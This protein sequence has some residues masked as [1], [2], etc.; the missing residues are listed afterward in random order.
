M[1]KVSTVHPTVWA[2]HLNKAVSSQKSGRIRYY[3]RAEQQSPRFSVS[4]I[5]DLSIEEMK[6]A[7]DLHY[8]GK[9]SGKTYVD[10][11]TSISRDTRALIQARVDKRNQLGKRMMRGV[12]YVIAKF[13]AI[14]FAKS[15]LSTLQAADKKFKLEIDELQARLRKSEESRKL[16]TVKRERSIR[17]IYLSLKQLNKQYQTDKQIKKILID[18]LID[19]CKAHKE[20]GASVVVQFEKDVGRDTTFK[21]HDRLMKI[22]D[23]HSLPHLPKKESKL[24]GYDKKKVREGVRLIQELFVDTEDQKWE[25][26][27]QAIV[28]QTGFNLLYIP[29]SNLLLEK[30]LGMAQDPQYSWQ[31]EEAKCGMWVTNRQTPVRLDI[32]RDEKKHIKQVNV[33]LQLKTD[34]VS[35]EYGVPMTTEPVMKDLCML[36]MNFSIT[37]KKDGTPNVKNIKMHA[38]PSSRFVNLVK[39]GLSHL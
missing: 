8:S 35:Q 18:G 14:F 2:N 38:R 6:Q 19:D 34:A 5:V 16:E 39:H 1:T 11:T 12:A 17:A 28:S 4:Q 31:G 37:L 25:P 33:C 9:L 36:T 15:F 7:R 21:R 29:L 32:I 23:Q 13:M 27:L 24:A 10:L 22:E 26:A 30:G 20:S 3:L